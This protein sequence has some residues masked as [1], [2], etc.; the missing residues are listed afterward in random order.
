VLKAV[1]KED[2]L[3]ITV[4]GDATGEKVN[5]REI[6]INADGEKNT[7]RS[8]EDVPEKFRGKVRKLIANRDDSPVPFRFE[9]DEQ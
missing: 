6:K 2:G 3:E 5:V 7:Y 4:I 9:K 1:Q 8:I